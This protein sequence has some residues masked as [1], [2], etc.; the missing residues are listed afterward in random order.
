MLSCRF[1]NGISTEVHYLQPSKIEHVLHTLCCSWVSL[2]HVA[3]ETQLASAPANPHGLGTCGLSTYASENSFYA[4]HASPGSACCNSMPCN[5][6][7]RKGCGSLVADLANI[8]SI[9][10]MLLG[11][12]QWEAKAHTSRSY[13]TIWR[14]SSSSKS[15]GLSPILPCS[16][17][18]AVTLQI[19]SMSCS[20][21]LYVRGRLPSAYLWL[22]GPQSLTDQFK[23]MFSYHLYS[24]SL[25]TEPFCRWKKNCTLPTWVR[26]LRN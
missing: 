11:V 16:S 19:W 24:F 5:L 25:H 10:T 21:S 26:D 22:G 23:K 13:A 7:C 9:F 2:E 15:F 3:L 17:C 1:K 6:I 20:R 18:L 14:L 12:L 8:L 4:V